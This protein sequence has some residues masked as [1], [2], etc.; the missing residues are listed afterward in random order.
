MTRL[1]VL[2]LGPDCDPERVSIPFVTYCHA[3]AL[4]QLHDVTLVARSTVEDALRRAKAPFRSI[5]VVR[6]P[7]LERIYAWS[8]RRIF[9]YNYTSQA[10][11]AFG[12][13]FHLAF[14]WCAWRQ[15][16]RRVLAGEFERRSADRADDSGIAESVRFLPAQRTDTLRDRAD[17]RRAPLCAG[18]QPGQQ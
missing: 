9:R 3:A 7:W 4:A 8:L 11:T 2:L 13:P 1:R 17:Q 16:R 18:I 10:L 14:E 5:E 15:L 12:Y 6:M